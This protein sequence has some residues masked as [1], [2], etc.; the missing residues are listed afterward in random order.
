M[1]RKILVILGAVVVCTLFSGYFWCAGRFTAQQ[2]GALTCDRIE[3][4]I[5]NPRSQN[6]IREDEVAA[7]VRPS[8]LGKRLDAMDVNAMEEFLCRT[9]AI[10]QAEAY[11]HGPSTLTLEVVQRNPVLRFQTDAGG[12]YCDNSGFILPLL[13]NVTLDLPV[14]SGHLRFQL[15]PNLS[16]YPTAGED[17]VA[18]L[19]H[20]TEAVR[21][22]PYWSRE[23]VQIW[24]EENS[25]I[26]L[27][28]RSCDEKFIFGSLADSDAKLTK[29]AGYL[30]TIRPEAARQGKKYT[31]VNL[32][33]KDQIICK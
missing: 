30:R 21:N 8:A 9:S 1:F 19:L 14:V 18:E 27:Y 32:K 6:F 2:A 25:D 5:K 23:I 13:N 7:L 12:F 20:L 33:Y 24:V 4:I 28:T 29:M 11:V 15:P 26:V 16:G 10:C 17:W 31:T 3:V 22:N